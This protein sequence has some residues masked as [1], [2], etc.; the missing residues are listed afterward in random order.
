LDHKASRKSKKAVVRSPRMVGTVP[1]KWQSLQQRP[2]W[3]QLM[4]SPLVVDQDVPAWALALALVALGLAIDQRGAAEPHLHPSA[5][6]AMEGDA[7][8]PARGIPAELSPCLA[9]LVALA[10]TLVAALHDAAMTKMTHLRGQTSASEYD[11]LL[12]AALVHRKMVAWYRQNPTR[13]QTRAIADA[14]LPMHGQTGVWT[15]DPWGLEY[16][17]AQALGD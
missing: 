3:L 10:A 2:Q 5:V 13:H 11:S 4:P 12:L 1:E 14:N 9:S 15:H 7:A 8:A 6:V 16:W 17:D